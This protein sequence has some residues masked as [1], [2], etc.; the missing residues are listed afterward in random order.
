VTVNNP[1]GLHV[2]PASRLVAALAGFDARLLLEK[3][4]K[5]VKPDSINQIALLQVRC[6]DTLRLIARGPQAA[7]ALAAFERLAQEIS[8]KRSRRS[9][10]R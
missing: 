2:R 6:H 4:G 10:L 7:L 3:E 9:N 1:N 5:C 8:A